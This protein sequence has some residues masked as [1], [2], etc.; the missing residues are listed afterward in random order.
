MNRSDAI[1]EARRINGIALEVVANWKVNNATT[2][3]VLR[4]KAEVA[5]Y[6]NFNANWDFTITVIED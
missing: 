3:L 2:Y 5:N 1:D 4:S 6:R